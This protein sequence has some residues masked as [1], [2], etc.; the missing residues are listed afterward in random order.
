M[1][2]A[3]SRVAPT[4]VRE[5]DTERLE[6]LVGDNKLAAARKIAGADQSDAN[7]QRVRRKLQ[8]VLEKGRTQ[9]AT[10]EEIAGGLGVDPESFLL[11]LSRPDPRV[12][13]LRRLGRRADKLRA[14]LGLNDRRFVDELATPNG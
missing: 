8:R 6:A 11:L 13:E 4:I 10:A 7:I 9:Q 5:V 1:T 2:Q 14:D 3:V 12:L